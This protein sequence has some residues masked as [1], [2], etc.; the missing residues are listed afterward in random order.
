MLFFCC[1][2]D[3]SLILHQ[4]L[5]VIHELQVLVFFLPQLFLEFLVFLFLPLNRALQYL[6]VIFSLFSPVFSLQP[7]ILSLHLLRS[8]LVEQAFAVMVSLILCLL[9][10]LIPLNQ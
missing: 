5:V 1:L 2:I 6:V 3:P 8:P 10:Q 7:L 9:Q 4:L